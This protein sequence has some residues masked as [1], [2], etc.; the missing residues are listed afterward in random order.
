MADGGLL[1]IFRG[2]TTDQLLGLQSTMIDQLTNLKDYT[3]MTIGG[4]SFTRNF[5]SLTGQLEAIQFVLNERSS[6]SLVGYDAVGV[7]DF[8]VGAGAAPPP[9][10]TEPLDP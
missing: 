8:S 4:K 5:Q 7:V 1:L 10:T 2:M 3:S 9:G 6:G